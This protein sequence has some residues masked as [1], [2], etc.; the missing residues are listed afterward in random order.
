MVLLLEIVCLCSSTTTS[1][2]CFLLGVGK[3]TV[4]GVRAGRALRHRLGHVGNASRPAGDA[5]CGD[6]GSLS[7]PPDERTVSVLLSRVSAQMIGESGSAHIGDTRTLE[8]LCQGLR[9]CSACSSTTDVRRED[10]GCGTPEGVFE[11][12]GFV[13]LGGSCSGGEK[14][15]AR[16]AFI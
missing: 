16:S 5:A 11:E 2:L 8:L 10:A 15:Q 1:V 7:T 4:F 12:G 6:A 13:Y 9:I 3:P 14:I